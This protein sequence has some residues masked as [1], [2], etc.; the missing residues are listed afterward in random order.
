MRQGRSRSSPQSWKQFWEWLALPE[1]HFLLTFTVGEVLYFRNRHRL[2]LQREQGVLICSPAASW[3]SFKSITQPKQSCALRTRPCP[4]WQL[5]AHGSRATAQLWHKAETSL[6]WVSNSRGNSM[7]TAVYRSK[8]ADYKL[9]S[10]TGC[11]SYFDVRDTEI[12]QTV[13]AACHL[14]RKED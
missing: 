9:T 3:T 12:A 11:K 5:I 4:C 13:P 2:C 1:T 8:V 7:C 6:Q 10:F 14:L